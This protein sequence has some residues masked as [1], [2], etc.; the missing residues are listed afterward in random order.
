MNWE[1]IIHKNVRSSDNE[2]AGN[3]I[4]IEDDTITIVHGTKV[5]FVIPKEYVAGFN[6]AEVTLDL[7]YRE[8][9]KYLKRT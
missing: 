3:V 7:P 8:L 2:N 5:E 4:E 9:G 6:G 1:S